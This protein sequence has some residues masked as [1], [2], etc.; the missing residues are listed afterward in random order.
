MTRKSVS[1]SQK[2]QPRFFSTQGDGSSSFLSETCH[3]DP[4]VSPNFTPP[5]PQALKW[6]PVRPVSFRPGR[7]RWEGAPL[8]EGWRVAVRVTGTVRGPAPL[9]RALHSHH[10]PAWS[11]GWCVS[12][13]RLSSLG[14]YCFL[15][16]LS[17][18]VI[19]SLL[20]YCCLLSSFCFSLCNTG[21]PFVLDLSY[22]HTIIS[23]FETCF[24]FLLLKALVSNLMNL[25][26]N[27]VKLTLRKSSWFTPLNS[28]HLSF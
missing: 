12:N 11:G 1:V 21:F 16:V 6:W 14:V 10:F 20:P 15:T 25:K 17:S 8:R 28:S 7:T 23:T 24:K 19:N 3:E 9:L 22:T 27:G 13:L 4:S 26:S 18:S 2:W 5:N